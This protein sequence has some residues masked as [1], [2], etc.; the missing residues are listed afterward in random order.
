MNKK[1]AFALAALADLEGIVPD[2]NIAKAQ[3]AITE[4]FRKDG[5]VV[6]FEYPDGSTTVFIGDKD[7]L[8]SIAEYNHLSVEDMVASWAKPYAAAKSGH[9]DI[10]LVS[11]EEVE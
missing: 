9:S 4:T 6:K 1:I 7:N 11:I 2:E 5:Y 3:R 8:N 10:V